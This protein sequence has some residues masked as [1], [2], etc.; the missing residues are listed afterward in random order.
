[1]ENQG[2]KRPGKPQVNPKTAGVLIGC[3]VVI[4]LLVAFCISVVMRANIQSEYTQ[5]RNEVGEE[6]YT[7]LYML[8]QTFDQVTVPGQDLENV[9][10]PKMSDHFLAARTLSEVMGNAFGQRYGV[11]T[12]ENIAQMEAAFDAY[13]AAFR[14]GRSTEEAQSAMQACMDMVRTLLQTRFRDGLILAG[15]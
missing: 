3:A 15:K 7:Q 12:Q 14:G 5:A 6:L 1:M 13:E 8:C 9:V 2:E 11:L 10:L 4:V